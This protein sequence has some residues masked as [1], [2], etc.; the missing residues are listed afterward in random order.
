MENTSEMSARLSRRNWLK[1]CTA[2]ALCL[3][4]GAAFAR[5]NAGDYSVVLLGDTHY[6]TFPSSTY[7][8]HYDNDRKAEWLWRVQRAEFMRNG[9][10]WAERCPRLLKASAACLP[11]DARFVLQLGDLVQ[12]D[13]DD[14]PTHKRMLGDAM[15]LMKRAY[16]GNLPFVAVEGNHDIRG[17]GACEAYHEWSNTTMGCELGQTVT[18]TTYSFRQG[19]DAWVV[20]DFNCPD[21][22]RINRLV[23]E[24][25]GARHLFLV[26]HGPLL[27]CD[28]G[29]FRWSLL[30]AP[31]FNEARRALIAK[32]MRRRAIVLAGHTHTIDFK[33]VRS[34]EGELTQFI[35]SAVWTD[36]Q[37]AFS[38]PL[39]TDP[40]GFGS[41]NESHLTDERARADF[42]T[43]I[44]EV[45]KDLV[46]YWFAIAAG[47]VTLSVFDRSVKASFYPG[48]ARTPSQ[49]FELSS[50]RA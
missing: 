15:Q 33:R 44:G 10:M 3:G 37:M 22:D 5:R 11:A 13:C 24:T 8:S 42:R 4:G 9:D 19:P 45:A 43:C 25:E 32:L 30:G 28:S 38:K 48:N 40:K 16:A 21:P 34:S 27:F 26:T 18:S 47:H 39:F 23:D 20:A 12:G 2:G 50:A 17:D 46:E 29:A 36:E 35:T 7:H 14:Q 31:K 41:L 49:M 6:D 1:G